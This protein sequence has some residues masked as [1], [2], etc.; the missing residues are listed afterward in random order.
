MHSEY[1]L[2]RLYLEQHVHTVIDYN[3]MLL[4]TTN[5]YCRSHGEQQQFND[6]DY[7]WSSWCSYHH[8]FA[9]T[10]SVH[11]QILDEEVPIP[12]KQ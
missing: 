1:I 5:N 9:D 6:F 4:L 2:L 11:C 8:P 7:K 10:G 3:I 12:K